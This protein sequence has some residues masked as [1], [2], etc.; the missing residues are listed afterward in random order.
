MRCAG[1]TSVR[2]TGFSGVNAGGVQAGLHAAGDAGEV[3]ELERMQNAG[4]L[5]VFD[6]EQSVG[7]AHLARHLGQ[8]FVRAGPTL[9]LMTG[10]TSR[11]AVSFMR[12]PIASTAAII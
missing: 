1:P 12:R 11:T 6:D 7:F 3:A 5:V 8:V 2:R 10:D 9:T 4:H